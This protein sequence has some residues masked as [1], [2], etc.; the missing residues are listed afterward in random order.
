MSRAI[1]PTRSRR[2]RS[3][4]TRRAGPWAR[5]IKDRVA[6][7]QMPPWHIDKTIG[8]QQFQNDRSLTDEQID[9]IVSWVDAGAPKG[10]PKDMPPPVEVGRRQRLELR[11]ALRRPARPGHQVAALH[12]EGRRRRTR[13]AS[14][15]STTGLTEAALGARD[16]DPPGTVKGRKI[17]HHA[18]ARLQQRRRRRRPSSAGGRRRRRSRPRAVHGV[19]GRQAGRDHARRTPAS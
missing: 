17:T 15:S 10:D 7:R 1:G 8:I 3:S 6:A 13:G 9:T 4:P 19:G 16:R 11:R 2:C 12:A 5:S 18:L 14:R